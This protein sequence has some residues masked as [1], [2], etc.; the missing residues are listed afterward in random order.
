VDEQRPSVTAER[1]AMRRA[2][3]QLLDSPRV[4]DDPLALQILGPEREAALRA[5]PRLGDRGPG[6]RTLRA[7][8]VARS[9][10]AEDALAEALARGVRDYVVL[11]AGLD[12]FAYRHPHD[13]L[14]VLEVDHPASQA[15]KKKRL[16]A[17][18][19]AVPASVT[20]VPIDF[21]RDDLATVLRAAGLGEGRPAFFS[22]LGVTPYL[23]ESVV[24]ATLAALVAFAHGGGGI[25]F[26]YAEPPSR[27]PL[28]QRWAF[29]RM[30]A[31]V[32]KAG[33]PF[34]SFFDPAALAARMR[35]QGWVSVTDL[36]AAA[37]NARCFAD[38][39]DGLRVSRMGHVLVATA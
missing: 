1:V 35:E 39:R 12:T 6:A 9:R 27:L 33:E 13:G 20:H 18:G 16:A 4:L 15:R 34:R 10:I 21:S 5:N 31:R 11:G 7:F 23:E 37:I 29:A 26:D 2:A 38:R 36:G 3:H 19:I 32:A 24:L 30:A 14:R 28:L 22:W 17:A 8:L 25:A